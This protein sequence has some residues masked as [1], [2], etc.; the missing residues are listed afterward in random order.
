MRTLADFQHSISCTFK[1][2]QLLERALTH[3]SFANEKK[4][5]YHNERM[6]FLGDSILALQTFASD[7]KTHNRGAA[8]QSM[9][10][11]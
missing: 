2:P 1:D 4:T 5:P 3:K 9:V 11:P 6:E 10:A 8:W 7:I